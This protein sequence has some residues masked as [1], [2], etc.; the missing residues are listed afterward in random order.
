LQPEGFAYR[1]GDIDVVWTACY[2]FPD[3]KGGQIFMADAIGLDHIVD[4][5]A[6]YGRVRGNQ[7]GYWSV[8]PL[9]ASLAQRRQRL[10]DV[11]AS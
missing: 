11:A 5:L 10:G 4:R 9:L 1:P 6:H 3:H 8:S 2:G 7:Y